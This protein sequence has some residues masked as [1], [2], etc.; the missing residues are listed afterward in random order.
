MKRTI[1]LS[2]LLLLMTGTL[3]TAM[4]ADGGLNPPTCDP[5]TQ[6]CPKST[7]VVQPVLP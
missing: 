7:G 1:R 5:T 4:L 6:V 3:S 2:L